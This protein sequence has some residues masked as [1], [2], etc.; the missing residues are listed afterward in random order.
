MADHPEHERLRGGLHRRLGRL[1]QRALEGR[2]PD[3]EEPLAAFL[4][5]DA[6]KSIYLHGHR[7][8]S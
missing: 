3:T 1:P 7:R 2:T 8:P 5:L 4:E 6:I